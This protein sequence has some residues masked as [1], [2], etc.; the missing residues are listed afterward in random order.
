MTAAAF[1]RPTS[2]VS[3]FHLGTALFLAIAM[4]ATVGTALGFQHIGGYIPCKLC[5]EQRVPYYVGVPVA[6]LAALSAALRLP[7]AVTRGLLA[8]AGLLMAYGFYLGVYH[9]GVE[10]AWWPG[11]T[12]CG[13][14]SGPADTG[15]KG[16]LDSLNAFVPPSCDKAALRIL[17][18]SF[19]GWNVIASLVLA[20][21][22]FRGAA[23]A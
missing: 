8:V 17:G 16:V 13:A 1:S 22:A 15:G 10:W 5:L 19:A 20:A 9:S 6:L 18:L 21:V 7:S 11:P 3:R 12:D 14:V 23:K 4:A 2:S